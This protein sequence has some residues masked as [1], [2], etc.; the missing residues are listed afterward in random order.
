VNIT[1]PNRHIC[2][3]VFELGKDIRLK[4]GGQ[5]DSAKRSLA[6][7]VASLFIVTSLRTKP[8]KR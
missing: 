6:G 3:V 7:I 5:I 8:A 2:E 1:S 4:A